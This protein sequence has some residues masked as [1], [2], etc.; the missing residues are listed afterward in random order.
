VEKNDVM[1]DS[2]HLLARA[3]P[4]LLTSTLRVINRRVLLAAMEARVPKQD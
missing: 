2:S 1:R 3:L 4:S